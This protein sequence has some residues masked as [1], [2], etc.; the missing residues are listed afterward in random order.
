MEAGEPQERKL[1]RWGRLTRIW[2]LAADETWRGGHTR[3]GFW[4]TRHS[5]EVALPLQLPQTF[6]SALLEM[7]GEKNTPPK[8][9]EVKRSSDSCWEISH[10][11][12]ETSNCST[13]LSNCSTWSFCLSWQATTVSKAFSPNLRYLAVG[14]MKLSYVTRVTDHKRGPPVKVK[15]LLTHNW[16]PRHY[17]DK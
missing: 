2:W 7:R 6:I 13:D 16:Y 14:W 5:A 10:L 3:V 11:E 1:F 9:H 17:E 12:E 4:V 8:K 15:Q